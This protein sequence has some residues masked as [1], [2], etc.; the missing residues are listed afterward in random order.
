MKK[1]ILAFLLALVMIVGILPMTAFAEA[2]LWNP[3]TPKSQVSGTYAGEK[4]FTA[5]RTMLIGENGNLQCM[6]ILNSGSTSYNAMAYCAAT[7]T[8]SNTD[9]VE[10]KTK[11]GHQDIDIGTWSGGTWNGADCLR[12]NVNAKKAG[13]A[14]VT[15]NFYYTF[16]Q[17]SNPFTNSNA[18]WFY[19]T[20]TFTVSVIDPT[21]TTPSKP[22]ASDLSAFWSTVDGEMIALRM[23]CSTASH[24]TLY[25]KPITR[26]GGVHLGNVT[27]N[28]GTHGITNTTKYPWICPMVVKSSEWLAAWNEEYAA[29]D[30]THYLADGQ[31]EEQTV[32]WFYNMEESKWQYKSADVPVVINITHE[33]PEQ[34]TLSFDGNHSA[35]VTGVP[36]PISQSKNADGANTFNIPT[37]APTCSCGSH[38]VFK[39]WTK[40]V[41]PGTDDTVYQTGDTIS[42]SASTTLYAQWGEH[43]H[44]DTNPADGKCDICGECQHEKEDGY[45]TVEGCDHDGT[46][47]PKPVDPPAG[48][49][50]VWKDEYVTD[51][52]VEDAA[53]FDILCT[54]DSGHDSSVAVT[55][56]NVSTLCDV[57][58]AVVESLGRWRFDLTLKNKAAQYPTNHVQ[59]T[60]ETDLALRIWI[61]LNDDG[62]GYVV[63]GAESGKIHVKCEETTEKLPVYVY[64]KAVDADST[65]YSDAKNYISLSDSDLQRL[66]LKYNS[67]TKDYFTLGSIATA[68]T[69]TEASYASDS[70]QFQAVVAELNDSTKFTAHKNNTSFTL[71]NEITFFNMKRLSTHYGYPKGDAYHLDGYMKFYTVTVDA[72]AGSDTVQNLPT[73]GYYYDGEVMTLTTPVRDGYS[74]KGWTVNTETSLYN[75]TTKTIQSD[76]ALVANWEEDEYTIT[77]DYRDIDATST[78][79]TSYTIESETITLVP[80]TNGSFGKQFLEWRDAEGDVVTQIAKGSH[81]D[82]TLYA[83]WKFPVNYHVLDAEGNEIAEYASTDYFAEDTYASHTLKTVEKTGYTFDGWYEAKED[84]GNTSKLVSALG[85]NKKYELYGTLTPN[86]YTV[87]FNANGG[88]AVTPATKTVTFDAAYGELPAATRT[89]YQFDGW[90]TAAQGGTKVTAVTIVKTASAHTLYAH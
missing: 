22:T 68:Q 6:P 4:T 52:L 75:G 12:I 2:S 8:S 65:N 5:T 23:N 32:Y 79:P 74:F 72:N 27:V 28:D 55:Y 1:R 43:T 62:H 50:P 40:A 85:A 73:A 20:M 80:A 67:A 10:V 36:S 82:I 77:Y 87:T 51:D 7:A 69:L 59:D 39:G 18:K 31:A 56:T 3:L 64:F 53:K 37:T 70:T 14:T 25:E 49:G 11:D 13:T 35:G 88:D 47:C 54:T 86:D 26:K 46:C 44:V 58:A 45:C 84:L 17:S 81:G 38:H 48:T 76:V 30:G 78:N 71:K 15:A 60:D 42:I 41:T 89:G 34:I 16:S 21:E 90:Y 83:Y 61:R 57:S 24:T 19:A 33:N 63:D 66:N 29:Q 9:V